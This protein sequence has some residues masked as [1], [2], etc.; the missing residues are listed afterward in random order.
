MSGTRN[1]V[2][3]GMF[4][5]DE[6]VFLDASGEPIARTLPPQEQFPPPPLR[7]FT[8]LSSLPYFRLEVAELMLTSALAYGM[9]DL[10]TEISSTHKTQFFLI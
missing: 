3:L 9:F 8:R 2:S 5:I 1:F 10:P 4:I 7:A 6:F